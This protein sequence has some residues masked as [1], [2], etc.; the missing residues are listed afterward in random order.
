MRLKPAMLLMLGVGA[1]ISSRAAMA[2]QLTCSASATL[3]D[4]TVCIRDQMPPRESGMFVAPNSTQ[5]SAW[6]S[7]VRAMMR[8]TC[9]TALPTSLSSFMRIRL[10]RDA[11]NGRRY[12][13]LMETGDQDEDGFVDRGTGTF[14]VDAAAERE[15]SHTAPHPLSDMTTETEAITIFKE[16]RSRSLVLAGTHRD[17]SLA[18]SNCQ[19]STMLSDVAHNVANMFHATHLE[20]AAHYGPRPWWV[21]S[22]HGMAEDTCRAV[23]VLLSHGMDV[24]P[25]EGDRALELRNNLLAY[26]PGW[27]VGLPG[28]GMCSLNGTTNVQGRYLNGVPASS[29]CG[30]PAARY[31][32]RFV[33]IEQDPEFR[34]PD[35]WIAAV[36]DTWP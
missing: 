12:C 36:M 15:L 31:S 29:V 19:S 3:E 26:H 1:L 24:P 18:V 32:G 11:A 2:A 22:W 10:L 34:D 4:L 35:S 16:T 9:N 20:L 30:R 23:D 7:V 28:G 5:M 33:H 13:V 21:I 25:V 14:I 27:R 6:R 8:G 17:A